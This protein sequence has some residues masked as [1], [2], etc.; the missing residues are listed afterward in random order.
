MVHMPM[1]K[2]VKL[3]VYDYLNDGSSRIRVTDELLKMP[4]YNIPVH[5]RKYQGPVRTILE[6]DDPARRALALNGYNHTPGG[7]LAIS[8]WV[9]DAQNRQDQLLVFQP[10]F[11]S[12]I[13]TLFEKGHAFKSIP[14]QRSWD[15]TLGL[16]YPDKRMLFLSAFDALNEMSDH[17]YSECKRRD[18]DTVPH[19]SQV[20]VLFVHRLDASVILNTSSLK[21][22]CR[23]RDAQSKV[24]SD[25]VL[26]HKVVSS[27]I[28]YV[29][30]ISSCLCPIDTQSA[31]DFIRIIVVKTSAV[32]A[33]VD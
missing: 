24:L 18:S 29:G 10:M 12:H 13:S 3:L 2:S 32:Q 30:G 26:F 14:D 33:Y 22:A 6:L 25:Q 9:L 5:N 15:D 1:A 7:M 16:G 4:I 31:M 20:D 8:S 28:V 23:Y 11:G 21:L 17:C 27:A 19:P